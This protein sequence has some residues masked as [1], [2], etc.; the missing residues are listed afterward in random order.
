MPSWLIRI[1]DVVWA[2]VFAVIFIAGS[3]V[4][5]VI[6]PDYSALAVVLGLAGVSSALLSLR[7]R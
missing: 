7:S 4:V 1:R 6:L 5:A 2:A 3:V